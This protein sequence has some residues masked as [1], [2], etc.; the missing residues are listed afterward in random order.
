M[1]KIGKSKIV[2]EGND[3]SIITMS[4]LTIEAIKHQIT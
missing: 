2:K 4:Y 1:V 3:L